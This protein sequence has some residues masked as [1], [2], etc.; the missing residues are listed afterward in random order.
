MVVQLIRSQ[1]INIK[2]IILQ[3]NLVQNYLIYNESRKSILSYNNIS[4]FLFQEFHLKI[5]LINNKGFFI[6]DDSQL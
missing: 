1:P 2:R 5:Y 6:K 3:L 4:I